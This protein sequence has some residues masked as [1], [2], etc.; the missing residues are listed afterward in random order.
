MKRVS[1]QTDESTRIITVR[2]PL[3]I[4][5]LLKDIT[6]DTDES[7]AEAVAA[8]IKLYSQSRA[9]NEGGTRP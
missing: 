8:A 4:F 6:G 7:N 2:V 9:A 5:R 1:T 3:S